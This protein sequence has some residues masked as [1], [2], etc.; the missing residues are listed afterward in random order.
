MFK[1]KSIIFTIATICII[2][3]LIISNFKPVL[4]L[5]SKDSDKDGISDYHEINKYF[6]DP[7][8]ID[9]DNDGYPD[10]VEIINGYSPLHKLK[11]YS[12]L[13]TDNDGLTDDIE[14][15]FRTNMKKADTDGDTFTDKQEID[16]GYDPK[17]KEKVKLSKKIKINTK[18]QKLKY[19]L[20]NVEM[21]EF[22]V[23]TGKN[24]STPKGEFKI[25][26]KHK[27]AWS[28]AAKLWMPYWMPFSTHLYG[29]HELPEWPNGVK[30]GED[31]LGLPVSGGCVRLGIG[32]AEFL[33]NWAPEGTEVI[34]E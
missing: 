21:G 29:L 14:L 26:K 16:N 11:M 22:I 28:R 34:I 31:H 19:L 9:T 10:G 6:T 20:D 8:N 33:Y 3:G 27:R 17:T 18:N 23:S 7:N 5:N 12:Q 15:K 32:D 24:D 30:E 1:F 25:G 4:S 13:D 2:F